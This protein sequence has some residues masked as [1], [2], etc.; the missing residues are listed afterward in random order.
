MISLSESPC[1]PLI[2]IHQTLAL[3][4]TS[5]AT[6]LSTNQKVDNFY[7]P[8]DTREQRGYFVGI[9]E[10]VGQAV[11]FKILTDNTLKVINRYNICSA[12][13]SLEHNLRRDPLCGENTQF[14]KSKLENMQ[15]YQSEKSQPI[16]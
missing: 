3:S 4:A 9:T 2:V 14:I 8:S 10:H 6:N 16:P 5:D 1:N 13:L 7:F 11:T 12:D 15:L